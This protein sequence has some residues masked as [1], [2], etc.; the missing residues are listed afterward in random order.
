[1]KPVVLASSA[2]DYLS[3]KKGLVVNNQDITKT[4]IAN[5]DA[6]EH[7][8]VAVPY[9]ITLGY[10]LTTTLNNL[11]EL[12]SDW[13]P[14]NN[15]AVLPNK[16]TN[17][18]E[19]KIPPTIEYSY[20]DND[21]SNQVA[22]TRFVKKI[23]TSTYFATK[24]IT[25]STTSVAT[26]AFVKNVLTD[27]RSTGLSVTGTG[28][29]TTH[30][31]TSS[32]SINS[33]IGAENQV[34]GIMGNTLQ[35]INITTLTN[36]PNLSLV[37]SAGQTT[38]SG[39][40]V[41]GIFTAVGGISTTNLRSSQLIY[42]EGG[43]TATDITAVGISTTNLRSSQL[44]YAEGG[45]TTTGITAVGISTTNLQSTNLTLQSDTNSIIVSTLTNNK[46]LLNQSAGNQGQ[47]LTSGG[48]DGNL[49]WTTPQNNL[50]Q[51]LNSSNKA[52]NS[53]G[54]VGNIE[55]TE[56]S[57]SVMKLN[58]TSIEF[59]KE[60]STLKIGINELHTPATSELSSNITLGI[61][62]PTIDIQAPNINVGTSNLPSASILV[63]GCNDEISYSEIQV[64]GQASFVVPPHCDVDPTFG[65]D[66]TNKGYV[67]RVV[68]NYSGNGLSLYFNIPN[69]VSPITAPVTGVWSQTLSAVS[70]SA[71]YYRLNS[72]ALGTNLIAEFTTVSNFPNL[73]EL[74]AGLWSMLIYGYVTG[75]VGKLSYYFKLWEVDL[76][77]NDVRRIIGDSSESS[78]VNAIEPSNP[79]AYHATFTLLTPWEMLSKGNRLKIKIYSNGSEMSESVKL[80]TL[81]GGKYYSFITTTLSATTALLNTNNAWTGSNEFSIELKT[82]TIGATTTL[83]DVNLYTTTSGKITLGNNTNTNIIGGLT[84]V[85]ATIHNYSDNGIVGIGTLQTSTTGI[86]QIGNGSNTNK[87]GSLK[88]VGNAIDNNVN[89]A[90]GN[91]NIGY[92]QTSGVLNIGTGIRTNTSTYGAINIGTDS[93][94]NKI[95]L[96]KV[97]GSALNHASDDTLDINIATTQ[98]SGILNIGTGSTRSTTITAGAINIGMATNVNKIGELKVVGA[99]LNHAWSDGSDI[100]IATTQTSG[101]L[102]IGTGSNR[103]TTSAQGAINI[104]T[105]TNVNKI[106]SLKVVGNEINNNVNEATGNINIGYAQT[107][108]VLNIGTGSRSTTST[109]GAI[110]IGTAT[111]VNK[112]GS[113]KVVG[114][115]INNSV[116]EATENIT[117]GYAQTSGVINIGTGSRSTTSTQ[118][119][120]NIGSATNVNKI[121]SLKVVGNEINNSV[122]EATENINIGYAQ[123][124]GVLNIG[125]GSRT[126]A[127]TTQG[128]INIGTA[129]NINKIGSLKVVGTALNHA[130][131]D[132]SNI[133]IAT[134]Q[135]S[136]VLNIGTGSNRAT[137][138]TQGAINIGTATNINKIGS[139]KVKGTEIN[140]NTDEETND[141]GIGN[142]QTSGVLYIGTGN[143]RSTTL[144]EGAIYIGTDTN[145]NKIGLLKVVG[146]ALNH[147]SSNT[148]DINIATAQTSGVLNI[149]TG[150]RTG[151]STQ[152]AINIGTTTNTNNIGELKVVANAIDHMFPLNGNI[153]IGH[154]QNN[155]NLYLGASVNRTNTLGQGI[156][157]IGGNSCNIYVEGL[158][159]A[160]KGITVAPTMGL[161][162][163]T[164]TAPILNS[165]VNLFTT[166]TGA[167]AIGNADNTNKIGS[168]KVVG[169]ALNHAF[170]NALN[171]DIATTQ[172]SGILNIGTGS[173]RSNT[174][175]GAINIGTATNI[176]KIGSLKV[177]GN[178]INHA[179]SDISD[180]NIAT[181]QTSGVL[182]IGTGARTSGALGGTINVGG[183]SCDIDF[184]GNMYLS[185][186]VQVKDSEGNYYKLFSQDTYSGFV[187]IGSVNQAVTTPIS[188]IT[189]QHDTTIW[190][191]K[192]AGSGQIL[193]FQFTIATPVDNI[194]PN[195]SCMVYNNS[196]FSITVNSN[197]TNAIFMGPKVGSTTGITTFN[198]PVGNNCYTFKHLGS[199]AGNSVI[200]PSSV[201]YAILV[202]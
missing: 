142:L 27:L 179:S 85:G 167:I 112:I 163:Q 47:V 43:I 130:S 86:V 83:S 39:M 128:A 96:L 36:T 66:L 134:T 101:I 30:I 150:N 127:S 48:S 148:L 25:D 124:S 46:L 154:S 137:S 10:V 188:P 174:A 153:Y 190:Y 109:A 114:N 57:E 156:I 70:P 202:Y 60:G 151:A 195:W 106:G 183:G 145:V 34:V 37:C 105:A 110:N 12:V 143:N 199:L 62:A 182:N 139:L 56:E 54:N 74:P 180:I 111:N 15:M 26:T 80:N 186:T 21:N 17:S 113:L 115:E 197:T 52:N 38:S 149:G 84:V 160:N 141:I 194:R 166:T 88:V 51:I 98:T 82:S 155:G 102:N 75:A 144:N 94:V 50:Q 126:G 42:A 159:R 18:N 158:I 165:D 89:E 53:G 123:T 63:L 147:A 169:T 108:G 132:A 117:I 7:K 81:F 90:T 11:N 91:I 176:N 157:T 31:N 116:N 100:N 133:D 192:R 61:T 68:G 119:A 168:L 19:F 138:S 172:T 64:N 173:N 9:G 185:N 55:L 49:A 71:D 161:A 129:T 76:Y 99:A 45:I 69:A 140:N 65:N 122:N 200:P 181:T 78:D 28:I 41:G 187:N 104:G 92:A 24:P 2:A 23:L 178:G 79:D 171:I 87:I 121:G 16:W 107:S 40:S 77:G 13:R 73:S 20:T 4:I 136:G 32:L 177:V 162:V 6:A 125:T 103:F 58:P 189:H 1:M 201:A 3:K 14:S 193:Q 22:T 131:S 175:A 33:V 97:V 5:V 35:W 93:N 135:T 184:N 8:G 72:T 198:I 59:S 152:G 44:I 196:L 29:T 95:G 120:I 191:G 170:D 67:D 164:I 118:G 146:T